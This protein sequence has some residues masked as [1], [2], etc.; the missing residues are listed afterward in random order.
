VTYSY[1]GG[2]NVVSP[3]AT[4]AY[5]VTGYSA[6]GCSGAATATVAVNALPSITATTASSIVCIG[7]PVILTAS[8][9]ASYSWNTG[10]ITSTIS[11]N[12][13]SNTSY[14]VTGTA[15]NGCSNTAV[16]T[17]SVTDC[18]GLSAAKIASTELSVYPNPGNGTFTVRIIAPC[19][20]SIFNSTGKLV[21]VKEL[22]QGENEISIADQANGIYFL[23][24]Q[25]EQTKGLRVI[26]Q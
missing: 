16:V 9:G 6:E 3:A 14:T 22:Q 8:G 7:D 23:Q 10:G 17:Q 2:S 12:P 20:L 11:V 1:T 5:T 15:A 13:T 26:K 21:D 4:S 25:G 19:T 18:T 24:I